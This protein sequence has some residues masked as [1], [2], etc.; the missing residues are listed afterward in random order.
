MPFLAHSDRRHSLSLLAIYR[1][2]KHWTLSATFVYATGAPYTYTRAVYIGGN[3]FIRE[4][5][6]YNGAKLPDLHHLD[7]SATYWFKCNRLKQSGI[8]ISVYNVYAHENPLMISWDVS[9]DEN[10]SIHVAERHSAL[11]SILP[12]ISWTFKF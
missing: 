10:K 11:Y 5:G 2:S 4:F 9:M 12:S 6:P 7:I 1:P 8:N 3:A